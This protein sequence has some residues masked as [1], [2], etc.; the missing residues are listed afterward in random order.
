MRDRRGLRISREDVEEF[1]RAM[2]RDFALLGERYYL[3]LA[4][5]PRVSVGRGRI[6]VT[7]DL[8]EGD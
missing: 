5:E 3:G 6:T 2:E 4:S 7:F 8:M 1:S